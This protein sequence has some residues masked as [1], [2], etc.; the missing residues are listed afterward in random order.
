M[1]SQTVIIIE[2]SN[3][4]TAESTISLILTSI[5][6][7]SCSYVLSRLYFIRRLK[8]V[9]IKYPTCFAIT[10]LIYSIIQIIN[11]FINNSNFQNYRTGIFGRIF[12]KFY[13][14]FLTA[15]LLLIGFLELTTLSKM[16][17]KIDNN[18]DKT[19]RY[20]NYMWQEMF[21]LSWIASIFRINRYEP[22]ELNHIPPKHVIFEYHFNAIIIFIVIISAIFY[23][24]ELKK[25]LH[26]VIS[27]ELLIKRLKTC[28]YMN[29]NVIRAY[30]FCI[31]PFL[32]QW[33]LI[34]F[35]NIM[36]SIGINDLSLNILL[37]IAVN[38]GGIGYGIS[39][40]I[41]ERKYLYTNF[42]NDNPIIL[43]YG[44][45]LPTDD[46]LISVSTQ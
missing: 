10:C 23:L 4:F 33:S 45:L 12:E 3:R 6:I 44:T 5:N 46:Q 28:D 8:G 38:I 39:Y 13:P 24:S 25:N 11:F 17:N 22:L 32:F 35:Y 1:Q 9:E 26:K 20:D 14:T 42:S 43:S 21:L 15:N 31:I 40:F 34:L 36:K 27:R 7:I 29:P 37:I 30:I 2:N 18:N 16:K 19:E 41:Y